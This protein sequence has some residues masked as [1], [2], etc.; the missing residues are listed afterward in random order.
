MSPKTSTGLL[1]R[2]HHRDVDFV[3]WRRESGWVW[4]LLNPRGTGGS[5]GATSNEAQALREACLSIEAILAVQSGQ[6]GQN[7]RHPR[8]S[9]ASAGKS[10]PGIRFSINTTARSLCLSQVSR[11][12][13]TPHHRCDHRQPDRR[14][15]SGGPRLRA[16][17]RVCNRYSHRQCGR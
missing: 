1:S 10:I 3:I 7:E 6:I 8:H 11:E 5:I 15:C 12:L 16:P 9:E 4:F 14:W 13:G 2:K 17:M